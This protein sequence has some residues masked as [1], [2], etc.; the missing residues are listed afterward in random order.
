MPVDRN[1]YRDHVV[2]G[3]VVKALDALKLKWPKPSEDLR[4]VRIGK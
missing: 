2:A 1:W 4:K 3:I